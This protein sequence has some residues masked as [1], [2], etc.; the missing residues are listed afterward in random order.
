VLTNQIGIAVPVPP[1]VK[2]ESI[3]AYVREAKL[4]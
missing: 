4:C 3:R 2:I 1:P